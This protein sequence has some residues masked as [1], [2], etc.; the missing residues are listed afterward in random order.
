M[1]IVP[2]APAVAGNVALAAEYNKLI[3]NIQDLDTRS[4]NSDGRLANMDTIRGTHGRWWSGSNTSQTVPADGTSGNDPVNGYI[5]SER[6]LQTWSPLGDTPSG[7][8]VSGDTFTVTQAGRYAI[9]GQMFFTARKNGSTDVK[10]QVGMSIKNPAGTVLY[11]YT[12]YPFDT[13][14][15]SALLTSVAAMDVTF[16]AGAQFKMFVYGA[17]SPSSATFYGVFNSGNATNQGTTLGIQRLG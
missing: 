15:A 9:T 12:A 17:A 2:M 14:T 13:A 16:P 5:A 4:T 6:A 7:I 3:S 11:A 1:A 8:T 10:G